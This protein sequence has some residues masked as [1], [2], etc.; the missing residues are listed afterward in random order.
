MTGCRGSV[1]LVAIVAVLLTAT[2]GRPARAADPHVVEEGDSL[3]AIAYDHGVD[4]DDLAAYNG[5]DADAPIH[6]GD[7]LRMPHGAGADPTAVE[8]DDADQDAPVGVVADVPAY[9][10]SRSLSCEYASVFIAT[11][12]FGDPI[13]EDDYIASTGIATNPHDGFR[14]NIDGP[15]GSTD[16]YGIYAEALVPNLNAHGYVGVVSYDPE[17]GYLMGQLDLGRPTIVW[18]ATRGDTGFYEQD[19]SGDSFELV[20]F[21]HVVVAYDYDAGG[22]YV[23][24]PGNASYSYL[25]WDWFLPAWSVLDGMALSVYPAS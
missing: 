23:S 3:A 21:E 8:P 10:Q 20:P 24:D 1:R 22:V 9:R 15:W 5:L 13:A 25:T 14:G 18:I 12:A 19:E 6:G 16:D 2:G 11:A 17:A 7:E 4:V